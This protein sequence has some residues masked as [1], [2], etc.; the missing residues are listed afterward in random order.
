MTSGESSGEVYGR[1]GRRY[2]ESEGWV[3]ALQVRR[4]GGVVPSRSS[5]RGVLS[6]EPERVASGSDEA[7]S[8]QHGLV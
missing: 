6:D 7:M 3:G 8:D 2:P 1:P 4:E 5:G